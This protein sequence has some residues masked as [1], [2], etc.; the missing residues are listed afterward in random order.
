M[1]NSWLKYLKK[2]NLICLGARVVLYFIVENRLLRI[3]K[4]CLGIQT[5][6]KFENNTFRKIKLQF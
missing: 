3:V 1:L 4:E 2:H 6:Q 5:K